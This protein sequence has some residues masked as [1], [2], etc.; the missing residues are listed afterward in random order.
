MT[1]T[2]L[3]NNYD[4][5]HL[6]GDAIDSALWQ[7]VPFDEIIV[8]DDDA[9]GES[10]EFL[11]SRYGRHPAVQIISRHGRG[12]SSCFDEGFDRATG[13]IVFFLDANDTYE[14]NHVEQALAVYRADRNCDF[15]IC[16]PRSFGGRDTLKADFAAG[17]D[18]GYSVILTACLREWIGGPTSCLSMRRRVLEGI[19]PLGAID[20]WRT[21][22]D[23]CLVL[24]ASSIPERKYYLAQTR[25]RAR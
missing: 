3:I 4:D 16:G 5:A 2:C 6:I 9:T 21:R 20:S 10:G 23:D 22:P 1:T 24:E 25:I 19:L 7:T 17:R 15:V 14:P 13:D 11:T 12:S 8:V 18:L